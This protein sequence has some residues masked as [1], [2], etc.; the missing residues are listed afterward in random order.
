MLIT[1]IFYKKEEKME[2]E[3]FSD[4]TKILREGNVSL[5][6]ESY[7]ELFSDFDPR[8]YSERTISDDFLIECKRAVIDKPNEEFELRLLMPK[9]KRNLNDEFRIKKRLKDHFQKHVSEKQKEVN[10]IIR[11][12]LLLTAIGFILMISGAWFIFSRFMEG[13]FIASVLTITLEP[14]GW[15]FFW[16][17]LA[18]TF[19]IYEEHE[20]KK[21]DLDFYKKMSRAQIYFLSY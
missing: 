10:N 20:K 17:G 15:F 21:R 11:N 13:T 6:L 7:N 8:N 4:P 14:A 16:E 2:E 5:I 9:S 18:K 1:F 3:G 19:F 12:G